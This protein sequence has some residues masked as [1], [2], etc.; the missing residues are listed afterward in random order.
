M[1]KA[2]GRIAVLQQQISVEVQILRLDLSCA[3]L[4]CASFV[5]CYT[6][7][8]YQSIHQALLSIKYVLTALH[9]YRRQR[10]HWVD[11]RCGHQ[12]CSQK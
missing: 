10:M 8:V 7:L 11:Y 1:D 2:A 4:A 12:A 6:D 9:V 5:T 3:P